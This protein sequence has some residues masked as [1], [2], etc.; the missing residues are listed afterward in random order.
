MFFYRRLD[1]IRLR[2]WRPGME[3]LNLFDKTRGK[4]SSD[5]YKRQE[6]ASSYEVVGGSAGGEKMASSRKYDT[7]SK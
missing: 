6:S 4:S 1:N 3:F 2:Q 5:T 7:K